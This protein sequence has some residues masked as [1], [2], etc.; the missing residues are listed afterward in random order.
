MTPR[1]AEDPAAFVRLV[2]R[3]EHSGDDGF[4]WLN[5][6]PDDDR[7]TLDGLIAMARDHLGNAP[8]SEIASSRSRLGR[9]RR[10]EAAKGTELMEEDGGHDD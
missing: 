7:A 5:S 8:A 1:L 3:M 6:D 4:S 10:S 9:V 2:A